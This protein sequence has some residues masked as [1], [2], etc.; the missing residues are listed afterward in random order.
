MPSLIAPTVR[1]AFAT[2]LI[3]SATV[4]QAADA[5][6]WKFSPGLVNRFQMNQETKVTKTGAGGDMSVDTL[7]IIDLSWAVKEVNADGSAVLEQKI[8]RM[9]MTVTTSDGLK[10]EIDTA[11]KEP[12]QGQA[13]MAAPLLKAI[14]G[15]VFVITMTPRGE[16]TNVVVP[17]GVTEALK[18]Q[19]GA[20]QMGE[21]A[22]A[23]GFK[24]LVGQASFVLPEA[25][26]VGKEWTSTTES[27]LPLVGT[28]KAVTTYK[29]EGP[30]DQEGTKLEKFTA[31]VDISFSGGEVTVEVPSQESNGEILFNAEAGR[32]EQS[33]ITQVTN[34]KISNLKIPELKDAEG[35]VV[36]QKIEQTIGVK[37][38]PNVK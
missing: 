36:E 32:L 4:A 27:K 34:L 22:S 24:K 19:P 17:D 18:N 16:V 9:R 37:W 25:L 10:S 33:K 28:Q 11:S 8:D 6:A 2:L 35:Q 30:I 5:I 15:N 31:K 14:T 26:T 21:L 29:Y 3:A 23:E 38:V 13:A 12:A 1:A 20:P 7:L